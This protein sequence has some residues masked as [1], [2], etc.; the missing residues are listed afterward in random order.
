METNLATMI[1]NRYENSRN[2]ILHLLDARCIQHVL[3][4]MKKLLSI[5]AYRQHQFDCSETQTYYTQLANDFEKQFISH[6]RFTHNFKSSLVSTLYELNIQPY[7]LLVSSRFDFRML[8]LLNFL[9]VFRTINNCYFYISR[10]FIG[11]KC[12]HSNQ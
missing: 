8:L 12:I 1:W 3:M 4:R 6:F 7:S 11:S 2:W 10:D 9:F 5:S